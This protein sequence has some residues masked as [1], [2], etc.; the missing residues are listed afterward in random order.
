MI[1][2][3]LIALALTI[4]FPTF[5]QDDAKPLDGNREM[6]ELFAADQEA[7]RS[8]SPDMD[9]G[10]IK[11]EDGERRIRT[12]ELLDAGELTTG[13]DFYAAAYIFQHGDTAEDYL[14]AHTLAIRALGLG[15]DQAE[16]IAAATL[17]RYLQSVGRSQIYGTQYQ[18]DSTGN[19]TRGE[20]DRDLI[21]DQLRNGAGVE[22]L[23]AQAKKLE[24]MTGTDGSQ[25]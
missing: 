19:W 17:D 8:F 6:A 18:S 13:P 22:S 10:E 21:T 15:M 2:S 25:K 12:R 5:A 23:A 16:W 24:R 14:L 9:W 4:G 11:R 7:R 20:F 1:R 3:L